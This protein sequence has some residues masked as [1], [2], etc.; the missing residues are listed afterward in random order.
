M[1]AVRGCE[2]DIAPRGPTVCVCLCVCEV[3]VRRYIQSTYTHFVLMCI[4]T[5]DQDQDTKLNQ[6]AIKTL[7]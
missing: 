1:L 2:E 7:N 3:H 5:T 4:Y 6:N